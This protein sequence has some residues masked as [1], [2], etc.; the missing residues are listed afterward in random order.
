MSTYIRFERDELPILTFGPFDFIV[1]DDDRLL[2]GPKEE[3]VAYYSCGK[4][5][6]ITNDDNL[7]LSFYNREMYTAFVIFDADEDLDLT[8]ENEQYHFDAVESHKNACD[9]NYGY[10]E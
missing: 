7:M 9:I 6:F 3:I 4:G 10:V 5:W 8:K 1:I 2:A